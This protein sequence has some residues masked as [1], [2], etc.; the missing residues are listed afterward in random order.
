MLVSEQEERGR[1]FKL[2]I[3]A[4]MPVL[5]LIALVGYSTFFQNENLHLGIR[6]ISLGAALV[7]VT[8]YFIFFLLE[9]D[10]QKT[11]IDP[12]TNSYNYQAF[13]RHC[14]KHK[15]GIVSLLMINNLDTI[16]ENYGAQEIDGMLRSMV[17]QLDGVLNAS[18]I[19]NVTIG[20][21]QDAEFLISGDSSE[22]DFRKALADFV[23]NHAT[24][25]EIELD[26]RF[27]VLS[28]LV[29]D[30]EQNIIHLHDIVRSQRS[31]DAEKDA[32]LPYP[33]TE[34]PI[35]TLE[36][37]IID[38]IKAGKVKF[39]FRPMYHARTGQIDTYEISVKLHAPGEAPLL[40]RVYLPVVNRLGLGRDYDLLILKHVLELL[41]LV[42]ENISF[43]F[44][45][46]PFSLRNR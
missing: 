24:V 35:N 12:S 40:P 21:K 34:Q 31:S 26:Y 39:G 37:Q 38:R 4:G 18:N 14:K 10:G 22:E 45:L 2:A 41:V 43:S 3:R 17:Y 23:N 13:V 16:N 28:G 36:R 1:K 9:E 11:L 29:E 27:A 32:E 30:C 25:N 46:S 5:A 44:N 15:S 20:R 6:E 33:E 7:F 19:G 8:T 42:D